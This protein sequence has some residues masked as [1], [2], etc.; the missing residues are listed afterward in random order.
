MITAKKILTKIDYILTD[1]ILKLQKENFKKL[2]ATI[3]SVHIVKKGFQFILIQLYFIFTLLLSNR[4]CL[5]KY[6]KQFFIIIFKHGFILFCFTIHII[7]SGIAFTRINIFFICYI[8]VSSSRAILQEVRDSNKRFYLLLYF[9]IYIN[10]KSF[11]IGGS[12]TCAMIYY[13]TCEVMQY[14]LFIY[15][16]HF[17]NQYS[18]K[19]IIIFLIYIF[20]LDC[21]CVQLFYKNNPIVFHKQQLILG[22]LIIQQL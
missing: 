17:N 10:N 15:I 11:S 1:T 3:Y 9:I 4:S 22:N 13:Q 19:F 2:F 21:G 7:F 16:V 6:L 14:Y 8:I 5:Q 18:I 20:I 12:Q